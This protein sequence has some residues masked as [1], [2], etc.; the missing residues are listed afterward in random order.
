MPFRSYPSIANWQDEWESCLVET[1][2]DAEWVVTE[3]L[4]GS[5][6]QIRVEADQRDTLIVASRNQDLGGDDATLRQF[7]RCDV[8]VNRFRANFL[9]AAQHM[10]LGS[11]EVKCVHFFGELYGGHYT[12]AGADPELGKVSRIQKGVEY[13]PNPEF[14]CFDVMLTFDAS[15]PKAP[16][17]DTSEFM[18]QDGVRALCK[19]HGIPTVPILFRGKFADAISYSRNTY[20][21]LTTVPPHH[22][23]ASTSIREGN[24]L[25]P[26]V[27][28]WW[29]GPDNTKYPAA[30]M[31][32]HKGPA[33]KEIAS[34]PRNGPKAGKRKLTAEDKASGFA[35]SV[36]EHGVESAIS[37]LG[38]EGV[39]RADIAA[40]IFRDRGCEQ[41]ARKAGF[42][43]ALIKRLEGLG[44]GE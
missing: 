20:Q 27:P 31:F 29:R 19:K 35:E 13:S 18:D 15:D 23:L 39:T 12:G 2:P 30:L 38:T 7:M 14:A 26:V 33:F 43:D 16:V 22:G 24:V 36:T 11:E 44:F 34:A 21:S 10:I 32:K 5:N 28:E 25:K 40:Q 1:R 42:T 6:L 8:P 37:K 3:K 41:L 17:H 4:H 9:A